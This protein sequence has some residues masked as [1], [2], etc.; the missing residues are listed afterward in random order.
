[1]PSDSG[2][3][4]F[5]NDQLTFRR[6]EIYLAYSAFRS[7]IERGYN[8]VEQETPKLQTIDGNQI[9]W[10]SWLKRVNC[11]ADVA[12]AGHSFGGA[13]VVSCCILSR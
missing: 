8:K 9:D 3:L 13:T 1:V 5:R 4:P 10:D 11:E 7:L 2:T 6:Q 12:L